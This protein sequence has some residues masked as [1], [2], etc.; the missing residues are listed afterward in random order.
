MGIPKVL[1]NFDNKKNRQVF[2]LAVFRDFV[3]LFSSYAQV[4][5]PPKAGK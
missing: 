3:A 2:D 1:A 4:R 5:L